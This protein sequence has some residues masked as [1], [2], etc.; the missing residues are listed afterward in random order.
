MG[1]YDFV[2]VLVVGF[3]FALFHFGWNMDGE[4]SSMLVLTLGED[5]MG[6]LLVVR[7]KMLGMLTGRIGVLVVVSLILRR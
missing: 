1:V 5:A 4:W 3:G 2:M 6:T 7:W